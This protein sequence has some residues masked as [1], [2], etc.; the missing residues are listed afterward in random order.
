MKIFQ[1]LQNKEN[2]ISPHIH[3]YYFCNITIISSDSFTKVCILLEFSNLQ[4][5]LKFTYIKD[6]L[7]C[8]KVL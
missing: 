1:Y 5:I 4:M 2:I 6:S 3:I 7:Y 8:S